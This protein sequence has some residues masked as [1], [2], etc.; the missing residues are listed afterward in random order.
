MLDGLS[1]SPLDSDRFAIVVARADD[2]TADAVPAILSFCER[3]DV[4]LLIARCDGADHVAARGLALAGLVLLEA[5]ITYRGP[6]TDTTSA[7]GLRQAVPED[8]V[9]IADLARTGFGDYGGHYHADPRLSRD[10]CRELYVDWSLRG[11]A[12]EAADVVY[13]AEI[14]G[15]LAAFGLFKRTGDEIA[16]QLSA[17]APWA[18]GLQLYRAILARGMAWGLEAGA[19]AVTGVVAHGTIAAHRNLIASGLR[20]IS[21]TSTFHGWRDRLVVP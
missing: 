16:F 4:E 17:V 8:A 2:V 20:P 15:R 3:H 12:G 1:L 14:D 21:S 19:S 13:V 10:A 6:L 9:G 11:L 18:R 7:P 5:Q